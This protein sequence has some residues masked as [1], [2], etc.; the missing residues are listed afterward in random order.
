MINDEPS[1]D[2][3]DSATQTTTQEEEEEA[4]EQ[5]GRL[6]EAIDLWQASDE[7][8]AGLSTQPHSSLAADDLAAHPF[9]VSHA[10]IYGIVGA[11][12]HLHSLR[13]LIQ[14]AAA[15]H[16]YA[17]F[18]LNRAAIEG[19]AVAV[20]LL[21]SRSR[22]ERIR[23]RLVL[24]TQN[25]RDVDGV[26]T[27]MGET[28]S[29]SDQLEEI[30][31]VAARRP[32]LDP[33][34]IVGSPPGMERIIKEAG[35]A[36]DLGS[37][38]VVTS[39]KACSGITHNRQ[40]ASLSFLDREELSRIANVRNLRMTASFKNVLAMTAVSVALSTEARLLFAKRAMPHL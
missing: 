25:A 4:F 7:Q 19:G 36:I 9:R 27:T 28:S 35:D 23:R 37:E 18:T 3:F 5:L 39:W 24:A 21:V 1:P 10:A 20:W 11:I 32:A 33:N 30:R 38:A 34:G 14:A 40:W 12:D 15:L 16:T 22:D 26:L 2:E 6:F 13:M 8:Q 17:P 29:L 31:T